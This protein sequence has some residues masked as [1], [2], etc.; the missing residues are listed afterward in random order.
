M[1]VLTQ[2]LAIF[3][4]FFLLSTIAFSQEI[5]WTNISSQHSLPAGV[6]LFQGERQS[7]ILK[8]WYLEVD[9][10][11]AD[12]AV[13]PYLGTP[14]GISEFTHSAGA[15][16]AVNGG[17]FSGTT[18]VSSVVYPEEVLAQNIAAVVRDNLTYPLTRS[19]FGVDYEKQMSVDWI[20]H[21]NSSVSG[22]YTFPVPN[23]NAIG[24]PAALPDSTNGQQY[25]DLAVGIGGGPALI[26]NGAINISYTEEVF[27]GSGVGLSNRDPRTAVG[28]TANNHLILFVADGRDNTWSEGVSLTELADILFNLG[29]VEAMNLDGGGSSQM[30]VGSSLI[31]RPEGGFFQ[32]PIPSILAVVHSDSIPVPPRPTYQEIIDTEDGG[33]SLIGP[34]WF[35][36]A[37]AGYWGGTPAQLNPRGTGDSYAHFRPNLPQ[38]SEY[39]VYAWWVAAPNRCLDTP[40]IIHHMNGIDTVRMD[41]TT[42]GSSWNL[43]GSFTFSGDTSDAVQISNLA[44]SGDFIVADAI[45]F[46]SFDTTITVGISSENNSA[47]PLKASLS[48]NFPNPFNPSTTIAFELKE[49]A[50]VQLMVYNILG[51]RISTLLDATRQNGSHQIRWN[52]K[53]DNGLPVSSGIYFYRF[54]FDDHF[55]QKKMILIR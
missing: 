3:G 52:G 2:I 23:P 28:F 38:M 54:I 4:F 31:N 34:G 21:F 20:Y 41:Q 8:A 30:A 17:Y 13:R 15:F 51:E 10:N 33:A 49:T 6:Q 32:R 48:Q 50:H 45:R 12:L 43:L 44:T 47:L 53:D 24:S 25:N 22:I 36:S 26:D 11:V 19:F 46:V 42:Q 5:T 27:W 1:K 7:P 9:M 14:L 35:P 16:A 18:S 40:F 29:C 55:Q 37:N 39:E